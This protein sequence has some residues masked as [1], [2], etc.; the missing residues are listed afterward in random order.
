MKKIYSLIIALFI[1]TLPL[2]A[3]AVLI[4]LTE[5]DIREA[6]A[7]AARHKQNTGIV[8]NNIYSFGENQLFSERIIVRTKRHKLVLL[9]MVKAQGSAL[10]DTEKKLILGDPNIQIDIIMK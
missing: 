4:D 8:L 7:F 10:S 5:D 2:Q 9:Y 1:L 3:G 6:R